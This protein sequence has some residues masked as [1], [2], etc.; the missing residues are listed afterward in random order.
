MSTRL[1]LVLTVTGTVAYESALLGLPAVTLAPVFFGPLLSV[2]AGQYPDPLCWNWPALLDQ[3]RSREETSS[4]AVSFLA[5]I[6][7][8]SFSGMPV[9]PATRRL[10][11]YD[12]NNVRLEA[13]G[14]AEALR[15]IALKRSAGQ[16]SLLPE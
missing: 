8:Q 16:L 3:Q 6:R 10:M 7:A 15:L 11:G 9:D 1:A 14:F 5:W 4:R 12:P 2:D 13:T